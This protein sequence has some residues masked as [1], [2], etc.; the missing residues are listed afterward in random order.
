VYFKIPAKVRKQKV[1]AKFNLK[2]YDL[3]KLICTFIHEKIDNK[4]NLVK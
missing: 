1:I 3:S 2:N 4:N